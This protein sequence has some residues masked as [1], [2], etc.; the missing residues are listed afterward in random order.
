M[1]DTTNK[2]HVLLTG[3]TG[4]VG[5]V[6]LEE[7]L[8]RREE[9]GL[10]GVSVLIR[11][12]KGTGGR[13]TSP[14]TRFQKRVKK[15]EVFRGLPSG[16]EQWVSV[17]GGDLEEPRCGLSEADFSAVT[18]RT[19]H[20]IHC[21]AS[22]DFDLPVKVA[23]ASN[24]TSA[25]NVLELAR[26]CCSLV[27]MVDVSTAYV[28]AWR[29]GPIPETLAHLPR[30]AEAL[31]QAI[32]DGSRTEQELKA[33]TGHPNTYTYTKCLAEHL[34]CERRGDVPLTIV[35]PSIISASWHAPFPG[36]LDSAAAFAGCLL[37]AGLGIVKAWVAD[38]GVRLDVVPVD[39]VS[40][41]IVE[42]AFHGSMPAPGEP[43]PIRYAV[44]GV[45]KALRVDLSVD[46]TTRFFRER[47]GAKA[48]PGMFVG[49]QEH[50]FSR[51]D[52]LRRGLPVAA[53]SALLTAAK[54][55][56]QRRKLEKVDER[57]RYM[58]A[59]F[60]YFT[61]H[62]F[63]FR[64]S[65]PAALEGYSPQAYLDIV[66]RSLYQHLL[67]L[68]ETQ[69]PLAGKAH[70]DTLGD[71][72]WLRT[73]PAAPWAIRTLGIALRKTLR[74]C[75]ATVTFDRPSF[76]RA[77]AAA[78]PD[79]LFVLAP[80]HRS[81]FDFLLM[82][83]LCFQH[84]ELGIAVPHIA[85]AEEFSR[86]P[87]VGKVLREARA[88]YIRR[89]VGKADPAV[90]EEL[91]RL[92]GARASLMFFVEGERSR[93]RRVLAPRRGLLR[94]LQ[95]TGGAF[96]VLP[97]A[98]SYDRVPEEAAFE[99]ELGGGAR[100][101]MSLP[102]ILKWLAQLARGQVRLGRIHMA[103]G[104][105]LLLAPSAD[106]GALSRKLVAEQQRC[107]ATTGFHLRAFLAQTQLEGVDVA[108]LSE[109]IRARGGRVLD[110]ALPVPE[111][112]T[113]AFHQSLR[114]QWMHWFHGDALALFPDSL[115]LRLHVERQG[116]LAPAVEAPTEDVRLRRVVEALF[117][118][119]AFD[120]ALVARSLG[121]PDASVPAHA[122][123]RA[124]L[125]TYPSAHLPHLEDAF[126]ALVER[127]VLVRTESGAHA[128][129]PRADAL[130][131]FLEG[132]VLQGAP[133]DERAQRR[134]AS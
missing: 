28:T 114:N 59:A 40:N 88:F 20:V 37:Y 31:Y 83:Y 5:K 12:E 87:V 29:P 21:A 55:N 105:P 91:R 123:A 61:H 119:V 19:T 23:A 64:P 58:N 42:A 66:N 72:A 44:M 82:S 77:V 9:L 128:W 118:P 8:R 27:G 112:M 92:V 103:C 26:A 47:P 34:L 53:M 7:L 75:T 11:P 68:D 56:Q 101:R 81:Y 35:R 104:E 71:V 115:A 60:E 93:A 126:Q 95:D 106:V 46:T 18:A 51:E 111:D 38:P 133:V 14:E 13:V 73:K 39:V 76:E 85:A 63:D 108:W 15:A 124:V 97:I 22:V 131:A 78:P 67:R 96:T 130:K 110:S 116:W 107:I 129:G 80:S 65:I 102:A 3:V 25:L 121:T 109:A 41:R 134:V 52:L 99:R 32:L 45:E 36:W 120:Y 48:W 125:E 43:V 62:T 30:P 113:A 54:K 6:V 70:D 86:I 2:A 49:R 117:A 89:G 94:G 57:V 90:G 24:I 100:S 50:G 69:M 127:E 33:E 132:C 122:N 17:V 10:G 4:F 79:T 16:W 84:P 98:I 74:Q 1:V